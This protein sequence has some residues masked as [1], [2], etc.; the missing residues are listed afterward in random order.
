MPLMDKGPKWLYEKEKSMNKEVILRND[1]EVERIKFEDVKT[2]DIIGFIDGSG[3]KGYFIF[4]TTPVCYAVRVYGKAH[5]T[6][7]E[8]ADNGVP[9]AL[10][11][12]PIARMIVFSKLQGPDGLYAWLSKEE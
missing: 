7:I 12:V 4:E 3:H 1:E 11:F 2:S 5:Y 6:H 10:N 8:S 9:K